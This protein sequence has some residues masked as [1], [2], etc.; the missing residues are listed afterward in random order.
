MGAFKCDT[1]ALNSKVNLNLKKGKSCLDDGANTLASISIP[2][3]FS[4]AGSLSSMP[5]TIRNNGEKVNELQRWVTDVVNKFTNAESANNSIVNGIKNNININYSTESVAVV[6]S[7][8]TSISSIFEN[9]GSI[10]ESFVIDAVENARAIKGT[11]ANIEVSYENPITMEEGFEVLSTFIDSIPFMKN[12]ATTICTAFNALSSIIKGLT[13]FVGALIDVGAILGGAVIS[14]V[15]GIGEII[16]YLCTDSTL[17][18][19]ELEENLENG[20]TAKIWGTVMDFVSTSYVENAWNDFYE[21]N[22]LGQFIDSYAVGIFKHDGIGCNILSGIGY[23]GGIVALTVFTAGIAGL[24]LGA[25]AGAGTAA[26]TAAGTMASTTTSTLISSAYAAISAFGKYTGESWAEDKMSSWEGIQEAVRNGDISQSDYEKM[27]QIRDLSDE[28]WNE[29]YNEYLNGNITLEQLQEMKQIRKIPDDWKT[30]ENTVA[31]LEYG[32]L[33]ALWEG[34]QWLVGGF[35]GEITAG[36]GKVGASIRVGVDSLFNTADTPF[37]SLITAATEGKSFGDVFET[38]GGWSSVITDFS[39]G[40]IG[41]LGGEIFDGIKSIKNNNNLLDD[42]IKS[43]KNNYSAN[44]IINNYMKNIDQYS[45][46]GI[47]L[48]DCLELNNVKVF[49]SSSKL[50]A[51]ETFGDFKLYLLEKTKK[52]LSNSFLSNKSREEIS[53]LVQYYENSFSVGDINAEKM[54]LEFSK[55]LNNNDKTEARR[56]FESG[57]AESFARKLTDKQLASIFNYTKLGGYEINAWLNDTVLDL[58]NGPVKARSKYSSLEEI[59]NIISGHMVSEG[60]SNKVFPSSEGS[61]IDALD[62]LISSAKYSDA[63]V[64]YR[65]L[66]GLYDGNTKINPIFLNIGDSF[67]SQGYQSSSVVLKNSFGK[68]EGYNIILKIIVPP[69][70]GTAAYIENLSGVSGYN[71]ME[72]LIKRNAKMTVVGDIEYKRINGKLKTI[73][74]VIVN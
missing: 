15:T 45:K 60:Q 64:T 47:S 61:I 46:N 14:A 38:N 36:F 49:N 67:T 4:Y 55:Y 48:E 54:Y 50:E 37:R 18:I 23:V 35:L 6:K 65:G 74:P 44:D 13:Q 22:L 71:Q 31:G 72:M 24:G 56:I 29:I 2:S 21:N 58:S 28:E 73:I 7:E 52:K 32:S 12:T 9:I 25:S 59:Q 33:N 39:I 62:S 66:K 43:I 20:I 69:K 42:E 68:K 26:G 3:N 30:A 19:D 5:S 8:T 57:M 53:S 16:A 11:N 51:A 27:K 10:I 70:S 63:I 41:S 34:A 40:L 17:S 1:D